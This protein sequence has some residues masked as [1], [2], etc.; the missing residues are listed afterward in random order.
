MIDPRDQLALS[1]FLVDSLMPRSKLPKYVLS[2]PSGKKYDQAAN[3]FYWTQEGLAWE[4]KLKDEL[5][6]A[7]LLR[8]KLEEKSSALGAAVFEPTTCKACD[9]SEW[10]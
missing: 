5:D 9:L 2:S 10:L 6:M 1:W 3:Q 7:A 4:L 8:I